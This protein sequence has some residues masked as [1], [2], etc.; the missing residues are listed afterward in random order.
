MYRESAGIIGGFGAYAILELTLQ[1]L[2][3]ILK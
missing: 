3:K 2:K 1:R